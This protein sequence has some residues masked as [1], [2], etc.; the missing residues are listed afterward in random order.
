M[1][2]VT[3]ALE[4]GDLDTGYKILNVSASVNTI[5]TSGQPLTVC[6]STF[7]YNNETGLCYCDVGYANIS[8]ICTKC[9]LFGNT[10]GNASNSSSN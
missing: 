6:A 10:T 1:N 5:D 2:T 8:N 3:A 9:N 4:S 7:L